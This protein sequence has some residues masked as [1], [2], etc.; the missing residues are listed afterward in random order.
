MH[1]LT[2]TPAELSFMESKAELKLFTG[3]LV[4]I[5]LLFH[6]FASTY[7]QLTSYLSATLTIDALS[8]RLLSSFAADTWLILFIVSFSVIGYSVL[9]KIKNI[10]LY[11]LMAYPVILLLLSLARDISSLQI[12]V[13]S[14]L[15]SAIVLS[16]S[17]QKIKQLEYS[18]L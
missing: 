5:Q 9:K 1:Q 13:L 12:L 8:P 14:L 11:L 6:L 15:S 3:C 10:P 17:Y 16:F 7:I 2:D 4:S 18:Q